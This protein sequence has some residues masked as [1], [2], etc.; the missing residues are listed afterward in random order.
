MAAT[1]PGN[2]RAGEASSLSHPVVLITAVGFA[3]CVAGVTRK[4][5]TDD[6]GPI[7]VSRP[8]VGEVAPNCREVTPKLA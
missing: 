7:R 3:C 5:V 6:L 1:R 4:F 8:E 2:E